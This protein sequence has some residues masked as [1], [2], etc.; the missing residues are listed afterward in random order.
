M[1]ILIVE[2]EPRIASFL[3]K[4]LQ[5]EGYA[6]VVAEDAGSALT[7]AQA[8]PVDLV[9][10]DLILPDRSGLDVLRSL[11]ARDQRLPILVLTAKDDVHSKVSGLDQGADDYLTKPFV[12]DEVLARVRALLRRDQASA[13]ELRAGGLVLDL[14][15]RS[16]RG[17]NSPVALTVRE[18]ALLELFIRH[19]NQVLSRAQITSNVWPYDTESESN[20][21]DVYVRYLRRKVPWPSDVRLETMRGAGYR[22]K[23]G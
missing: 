22:L 8:E 9:L 7:F 17:T 12:F 19:P 23:V 15:Q 1:L 16:V 4:G 20:V 21:V 11:R 10:L 3:Q 14:R 6:C 13:V 2:D 18:S 5:A